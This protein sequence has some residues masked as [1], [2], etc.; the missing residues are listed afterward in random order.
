MKRAADYPFTILVINPINRLLVRPI[1]RTGLSPNAV[2]WLSF[3]LSLVAAFALFHAAQGYFWA[4]VSAPLLVLSSHICDAL[5]GDLARYTGKFSDFGG[6]L[7]PI[8]DRVGEFAYILAVGWGVSMGEVGVAAWLPSVLCLGGC[9][10]YYY[11]TDAQVSRV[12][13]A[14][15]NDPR[16]YSVMIGDEK[17]PRMKLGLYEPFMYGLALGTSLGFGWETLWAFA[18]LFWLGSIGQLVKLYKLAR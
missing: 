3:V 12:L 4:M 7:D 6:A 14:R 10:V 17:K 1:S 2:T 8:L 16:R 18:G 11:I 5:D 13:D 9:L 15:A